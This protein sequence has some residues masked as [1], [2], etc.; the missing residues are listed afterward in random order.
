MPCRWN[1]RRFVCSCFCCEILR[2]LVTKDEFLNAVW[3]DVS[4]SDNSL[5]RS[6]AGLAQATLEMTAVS[7]DLS[8]LCPR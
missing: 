8:Q 6:I 4:V 7:H 2:R 3:D 5:T 1:R